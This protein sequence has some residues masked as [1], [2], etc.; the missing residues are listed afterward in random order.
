M[1]ELKRIT[2]EGVPAALEKALRYRLLNEPLEAESICRDI[3]ELEPENK[4]A[5]VTLLLSLTDQFD[6]DFAHARDR[7][8]E[9]L[10]QLTD[11]YQQAYYEGILHERWAKAEIA[12]GLPRNFAV[13]W[14]REAM[15]CYEKAEQLS[16]TKDPDP[17]LRWN[18][19]A[20]FLAREGEIDTQAESLTHD[21]HEGFPDDVPPR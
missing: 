3:L 7:A 20:R 5:V 14:F 11:P 10:Q 16:T 4:Q 12:R 17:I 2:I 15:R 9:A 8:R 21:A 19:C 6:K 13:G 1:I 18:T